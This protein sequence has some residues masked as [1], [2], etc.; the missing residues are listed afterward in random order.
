[1]G[2]GTYV[3]NMPDMVGDVARPD[4]GNTLTKAVTSRYFNAIRDTT[5]LRSPHQLGS[6]AKGGKSYFSFD[7]PNQQ[8]PAGFVTVVEALIWTMIAGI[9]ASSAK[10]PLKRPIPDSGL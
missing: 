6:D 2:G 9:R 5:G 3:I 7:K 8:P 10:I 4:H 1:M